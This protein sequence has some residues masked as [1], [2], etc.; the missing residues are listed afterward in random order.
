[1]LTANGVEAGYGDIQ[2][3]RSVTLHVD[4]GE[5]VGLFGPNGHGKT[6][7]LRAVSGLVPIWGGSILYDEQRIDGASPDE[8]LARGLVHVPQGSTLFPGLTVQENLN[9]GAYAGVAWKERRERMSAVF[10]TFPKLKD[11]LSQEAST[12]SGGERQMVSMGIGLMAQPKMLLLDEPTLGLAPRVK[13]ELMEAISVVASTGV[14]LLVVDQDIEFLLGLT[15][16]LYLLEG[17]R[18]A[19]ETSSQSA[20]DDRDILS[21]YFGGQHGG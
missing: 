15:D 5:C 10:A 8:I 4:D 12:L 18:I 6:T 2:V 1:M 7:L 16:R 11:R 3:L 21:I 14:T 13:E 9:L 20:F 19:L 17:G